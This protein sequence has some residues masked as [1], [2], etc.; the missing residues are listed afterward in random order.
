VAA[1]WEK[2]ENRFSLNQWVE[3]SSILMFCCDPVHQHSL[4]PINRA[5]FARA[6]NLL[7]SQHKKTAGNTW[8][9]LDEVREAG[10]LDGL[11]SLLN[12][13][14][15]KGVGVV[16]GFQDFDGMRALYGN[17]EAHEITGQANNKTFLR[18]DSVAT[19]KWMESNAGKVLVKESNITFD[20]NSVSLPKSV[21]VSRT[22]RDAVLASEFL[23][24]PRTT[25]HSG[26]RGF[27]LNPLIGKAYWSSTEFPEVLTKA[28]QPHP[29][30]PNFIPRPERFQEL[31]P[32]CAGDAIKFE[33]PIKPYAEPT[34]DRAQ[35]A[36]TETG[37]T[38]PPT[39]ANEV[40]PPKPVESPK[41]AP[42]NEEPAAPHGG[43]DA[44]DRLNS[45]KRRNDEDERA[46]PEGA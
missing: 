3:E 1:L 8:V 43:G 18:T 25:P 5:I 23:E 4:E 27:H 45:V 21:S 2:A 12:L 17:E 31:E 38:V 15:S 16:L 36:Q 28:G 32:W 19:A 6:S 22:T 30:V 39:E 11:R 20:P 46:G 14:R 37:N 9:F 24:I 33:I 44:L 26:L 13:G 40:E 35:K 7:L 34:E 42:H 41:E 29:G 10:K